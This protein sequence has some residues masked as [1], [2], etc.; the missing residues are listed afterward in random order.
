MQ[1]KTLRAPRTRSLNALGFAV[2]LTPL[3][4]VMA[5]EIQLP[6]ITVGAAMRSSFT[7]TDIDGEPEDINDFAL[8]SVRVFLSGQATE[9]IGMFFRTDY[10]SVDEEIR[11]IDA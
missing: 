3:G 9:N 6:P 1:R 11:V 8:N 5:A 2:L 7:S 4:T 10:D